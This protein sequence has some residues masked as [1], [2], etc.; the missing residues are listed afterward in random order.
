M[1]DL[2]P[3]D[4]SVADGRVFWTKYAYE[5]ASRRSANSAAW[6]LTTFFADRG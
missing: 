4:G 5:G 1:T 3:E 6:T 2:S